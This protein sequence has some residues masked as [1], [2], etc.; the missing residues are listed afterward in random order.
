MPRGAP[1]E[2]AWR[3]L[4]LPGGSLG[5]VGGT[6]IFEVFLPRYDVFYLT[7]APK[8]RLP[9]GVPVFAEVPEKTPEDVLAF[10]GLR[11]DPPRV[12]D[13]AQHLMV[14]AWRR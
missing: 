10:H 9:G 2:Q 8:V 14:T 3:A 5:V 13:A 7:R 12:L 1:F 4:D 11:A 6:R